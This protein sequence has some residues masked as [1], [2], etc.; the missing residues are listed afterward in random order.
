MKETLHMKTRKGTHL[1]IYKVLAVGTMLCGSENWVP[2]KKIKQNP[3]FRYE[4][5]VCK[6]MQMR[7]Q[8]MEQTCMS[9]IK[10]FFPQLQDQKIQK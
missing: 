4:Y 10:N 2:Q 8:D 9:R 7:G 1:K 6:R 3:G 5:L